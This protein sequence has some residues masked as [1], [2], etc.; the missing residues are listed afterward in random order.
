[1][2]GDAAAG[3]ALE[4]NTWRTGRPLDLSSGRLSH[5][6]TWHAR[7]AG[8]WF[9]ECADLDSARLVSRL[10]LAARRV[11]KKQRFHPPGIKAE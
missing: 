3:G 5:W 2:R 8:L 7:G 1:M 9:F 11:E 4:G 6:A 10:D